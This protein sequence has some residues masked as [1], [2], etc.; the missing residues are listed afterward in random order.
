MG[1]GVPSLLTRDE[2][3]PQRGDRT[4]RLEEVCAHQQAH[5]A[6]AAS[7]GGDGQG[8]EGPGGHGFEDLAGA[9]PQILVVGDGIN[10]LDASGEEVVDH[11]VHRLHDNGVQLVFSGLK[12]QI[13]Q[14]MQRT[15]LLEHIGQQYI[16]ATADQ[17]LEAIYQQLDAA[18]DGEVYCP[19]RPGFKAENYQ[20]I[21][22]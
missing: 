19:L 12:R 13:L 21:E 2:R 6:L 18:A 9:V 22:H 17:A 8:R 11:L 3:P 7:V 20:R 16:H 14:I 15:N 4:V 5:D 10:E 1:P